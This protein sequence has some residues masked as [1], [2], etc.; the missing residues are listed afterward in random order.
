MLHGGEVP[1]EQVLPRGARA[2]YH[3]VLRYSTQENIPEGPC[4]SLS[5]SSQWLPFLLRLPI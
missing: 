5:G 1:A 3:A 2:A 4:R